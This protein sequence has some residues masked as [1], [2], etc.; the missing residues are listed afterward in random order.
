MIKLWQFL[1]HG[2]WHDWKFIN[3]G[4]LEHEGNRVGQYYQY[5]CKKCER[6]EDRNYV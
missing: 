1:W 6:I 2:C 3:K 5:Q 4:H